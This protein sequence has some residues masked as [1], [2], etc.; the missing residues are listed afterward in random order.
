MVIYFND[1]GNINTVTRAPR[2]CRTVRRRMPSSF[3]LNLTTTVYVKRIFIN[4][5]AES[6]LVCD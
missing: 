1:L 4:A 3:A 6:S 5:T 2:L